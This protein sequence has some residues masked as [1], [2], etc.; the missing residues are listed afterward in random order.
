[1][2]RALHIGGHKRKAPTPFISEREKGG[3]QKIARCRYYPCTRSLNGPIS[4][5]RFFLSKT[6]A[7]SVGLI[8]LP[9]FLPAV[10][11]W[12]AVSKKD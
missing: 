10:Y 5:I 1:M 7:N 2:V 4:M 3:P 11:L 8:T 9:H 12:S 6:D